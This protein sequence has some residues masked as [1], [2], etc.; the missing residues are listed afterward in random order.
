MGAGSETLTIVFTDLVDSTAIRARVGEDRADELQAVHLRLLQGVVDE[1]RGRVVKG[2]G[3]GVLAVFDSAADAVDAA[4]E[5]QRRT[6]HYSA[7]D[8]AIGPLVVKVGIS[9]GDVA[10]DAQDDISGTAANEAARIQGLAEGGQILCADL[11]KLVARGRGDHGYTSLG[12]FELK[13]L[14]HP[15]AVSEVR[16]EPIAERAAA[17]LP[18]A[19]AVAPVRL[20]GREREI[21]EVDAALQAGRRMIV[22]SGEPGIGKTTI[23]SAVARRIH[24]RGGAVLFGRCDRDLAVPFHPLIEAI[25]AWVRSLDDDVRG[26]QV[27]QFPMLAR[28]STH[29]ARH[30][31]APPATA[32][33]PREQLALFDGIAEWLVACNALLVIDDVQWATDATTLLIRHLLAQPGSAIRMLATV[34]SDEVDSLLRDIIAEAETAGRL[35]RVEIGGLDQASVRELGFDGDIE[36]LVRRTGGNPLFLEALGTGREVTSIESAVQR[37]VQALDD[38]VTEVLRLAAVIGM[39]IDVAVLEQS[40][41]VDGDD[42]LDALDAA[43][44]H[45]IVREVGPGRFSFGHGL[46]QEAFSQQLTQTRRQR[47]HLRV[48]R[49]IET[50]APT[51]VTSLARHFDLGGDVEKAI[52]YIKRA[53][54]QAVQLGD[55]RSATAHFDRLAELETDDEARLWAEFYA[56]ETEINAGRYPRSRLERALRLMREAKSR[57]M[58]ELVARTAS[59]MAGYATAAGAHN[60]LVTEVINYVDL[61]EIDDPQL[62]IRAGAALTMEAVTNRGDLEGGRAIVDQLRPLAEASGDPA[63]L[64]MFYTCVAWTSF[65]G[66]SELGIALDAARR[67]LDLLSPDQAAPMEALGAAFMSGVYLLRAGDLNGAQRASREMVELLRGTEFLIFKHAARSIDI[68]AHIARGE[69]AEAERLIAESEA[70]S[71]N[72]EHDIDADGIYAIEQFAIRRE[73][74]RLHEIAR[75]LQL[76]MRIDPQREH[77]WRPG[78][79]AMCAEVGMLNE[80][81]CELDHLLADA[82]ARLPESHDGRHL[83]A[84]SFCVDAAVACD[85]SAAASV[86]IELLEPWRDFH[87]SSV[88]ALYLGPVSRQLGRLCH[89]RGRISEAEALLRRSIDQSQR[90]PTPVFEARSRLELGALL[91]EH[92]RRVEARQEATRAV[93]I[94]GPL[95]MGVVHRAALAL[96][97]STVN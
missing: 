36:G 87:V 15:V 24:E 19:L 92:D 71:L 60:A 31:D 5:M 70:S 14:P 49:V 1:C 85:D 41:D 21:D 54:E 74:G 10:W 16:W 83:M 68:S 45:R 17:P 29:A 88:G 32:S 96:A 3:D 69:F 80:A 20:V 13:G 59:H 78:L 95:G 77:V 34:R 97:T 91:A 50:R 26:E 89:L 86:L 35:S 67:A 51:E 22:L 66:P 6:T 43:A 90:A 12:E 39:E 4:V 40:L 64:A 2:L 52:F 63:A 8:D 57:N 47:L 9:T 25:D 73:Q 37:R 81:Q 42:I 72:D 46:V 7:R 48:A 65:R 44:S 94:A 53:A 82:G 30:V 62:K 79:A 56:L 84:L 11:T 27:R 75:P 33:P 18:E 55:P 58:V 38:S 61:D 28:V 76:V 23:A 93:E